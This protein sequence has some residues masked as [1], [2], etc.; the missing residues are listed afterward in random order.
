M[1]NEGKYL[2]YETRLMFT[3][4]MKLAFK[5]E[6]LTEASVVAVEGGM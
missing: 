4:N 1:S 2:L 5:Q 3:S 6:F